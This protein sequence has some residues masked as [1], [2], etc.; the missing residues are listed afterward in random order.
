[1]PIVG[2]AAARGASV[3]MR[4]RLLAACRW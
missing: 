4:W 3:D 2:W 1:M